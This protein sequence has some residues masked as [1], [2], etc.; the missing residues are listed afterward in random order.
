M[1][2]KEGNKDSSKSST[3]A[4]GVCGIKHDRVGPP[5]EEMEVQSTRD[6]E[7]MDEGDDDSEITVISDNS[8]GNHEKDRQIEPEKEK[9]S[10]PYPSSTPTPT[11]NIP[12]VCR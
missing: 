6:D 12:P 4:S 11:S 2:D 9:N 8:K 1:K 3:P 7:S 5:G 10:Y